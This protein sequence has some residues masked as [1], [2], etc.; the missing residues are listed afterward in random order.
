[1]FQKIRLTGIAGRQKQ[2]DMIR[3]LEEKVEESEDELSDV[4]PILAAE[5]TT[6]H[7]RPAGT[8]IARKIRAQDKSVFKRDRGVGFFETFRT[9]VLSSFVLKSVLEGNSPCIAQLSP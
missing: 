3:H 9:R 7:T 4:F 5:M 1:M 6:L 8:T 2:R